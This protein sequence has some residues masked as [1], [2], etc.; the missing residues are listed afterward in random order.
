MFNMINFTNGTNGTNWI[1]SPVPND[2]SHGLCLSLIICAA[3]G[4]MVASAYCAVEIRRCNLCSLFGSALSSITAVV[5]TEE[6]PLNSDGG[7][8]V[9]ISHS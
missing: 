4:L 8:S 1:I 7:E 9:T 3:M 6:T 5:T 2:D